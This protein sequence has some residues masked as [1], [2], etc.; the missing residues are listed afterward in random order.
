MRNEIIMQEMQSLQNSTQNMQTG[1]DEM[2][3]GARKINSTGGSLEGISTDV[4]SAIN[5]IGSQIDLFKTE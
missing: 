2:A 3:N 5:K 4:Q 1:M